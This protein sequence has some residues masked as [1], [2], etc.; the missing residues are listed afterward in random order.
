MNAT[1][2]SRCAAGWLYS[3]FVMML[4]WQLLSYLDAATYTDANAATYD[5]VY[6]VLASCVPQYASQPVVMHSV[7]IL[8][9]GQHAGT[10]RTVRRE[11]TIMIG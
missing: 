7:C 11:S 9:A 1:G 3:V 4:A 10:I 6:D 2:G 5:M 8:V